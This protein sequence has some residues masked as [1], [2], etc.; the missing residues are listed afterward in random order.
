[1]FWAWVSQDLGDLFGG[2]PN[3]DCILGSILGSPY[4]GKLP[5]R[6]PASMDGVAL[7]LQQLLHQVLLGF[8]L[9]PLGFRGPGSRV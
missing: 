4:F 2:P 3:K 1:M 8:V 9:W 5:H 7:I 6:G